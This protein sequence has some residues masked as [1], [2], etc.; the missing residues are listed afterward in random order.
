MTR[1]EPRVHAPDA[2]RKPL[3]PQEQ[4][5]RKRQVLTQ[6][7]PSTTRSIAEAV[8]AKDGD[9][10]F[11]CQPDGMV[12]LDGAHALGLYYHDCRYLNGYEMT[13][14]GV[15]PE[16]LLASES[17]GFM[18]NFQ[19]SN[20]KIRTKEGQIIRKEDIGIAWERVVDGG[21][22]TLQEALTFRNFSLQPVEFPVSLTFRAG[23]EDVF[24]IRGLLPE[25]HGKLSRPIWKDSVLSFTYEGADG[26]YRSLSVHADPHPES[27]AG[28]TAHFTVRLQPRESKR[29]LVDL[30]A[31]SKPLLPDY[32]HRIEVRGL[33]VGRAAA[34]L[35]FR[36]A[37]DGTTQLEVLKVEGQLDVRFEP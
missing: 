18:V 17:R 30:V 37:P 19:F 25:K 24:A 10:F 2:V 15:K 35:M 4:H 5:E 11:L 16:V 8:V 34:D 7:K 36:R 12:P 14:A 9:L 20:P 13:I 3:T 28:T 26:L 27:E 6:G 22:H 21:S 23:F 32:V 1:T 31:E 29:L 33:K